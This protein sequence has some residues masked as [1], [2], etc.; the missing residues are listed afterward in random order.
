ML[1]NQP[2][3]PP[4]FHFGRATHYFHTA[5]QAQGN[6]AAG[7][8]DSLLFIYTQSKTEVELD[9]KQTDDTKEPT[10]LRSGTRVGFPP[11]AMVSQSTSRRG[12]AKAPDTT[13]TLTEGM[14]RIKL[15]DTE[16]DPKVQS[17]KHA[18][19]KVSTL[20]M[21]PAQGESGAH[22]QAQIGTVIQKQAGSSETRN[23]G[24][25]KP[26]PEESRG[27]QKQVPVL[28]GE[29]K[30]F[31]SYSDDMYQRAVDGSDT[32]EDG[33][34]NWNSVER[35]AELLKQVQSAFV[36]SLSL[37]TDWLSKIW[38]QVHFFNLNWGWSLNGRK[39]LIYV[40]TKPTELVVAGEL[41]QWDGKDTMETLIGLCFA[42]IDEK[43][44]PGLAEFMCDG[45][46]VN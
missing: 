24:F 38:G 18:P 46:H 39:V 28:S 22:W 40:R 6:R 3:I 13:T 21:P 10:R 30:T 27:S 41:L 26:D 2:Q 36:Y 20:A 34:F 15:G 8:P 17:S 11:P 43:M 14:Q 12:R 7:F 4:S 33:R 1:G 44:R 42:S 16:P 25:S 45:S 29:V 32:L 19:Q 31:W 37:P 9:T 23:V 5:R 35:S